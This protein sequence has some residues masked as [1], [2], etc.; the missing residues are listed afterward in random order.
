MT[1]AT[2]ENLNKVTDMVSSFE[3]RIHAIGSIFDSSYCLVEEFQQTLVDTRDERNK[4]NTDLKENLAMNISFRK[5]DFDNMLPSILSIQDGKEKIIRNS[6]NSYLDEQKELVLVL[7]GNLKKFK[8][9]LAQGEIQ[10]LKEYRILI[11]EILT[12]QDDRK[13]E[14]ILELKEFQRD[15]QE[16]AKKMKELLAKG[17]ELRIRDLKAIFKEFKNQRNER[18][19]L[20]VERRNKILEMLGKYSGEKSKELNG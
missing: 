19:S 10:R 14:I 5:K 15:Q 20:N 1:L 16:M 6:L 18:K 12:I 8:D 9:A 3:D 2:A 13:T 11:K 17:R 7:R 4:L